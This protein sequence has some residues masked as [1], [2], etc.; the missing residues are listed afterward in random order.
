MCKESNRRVLSLEARVAVIL[1]T[2]ASSYLV[3]FREG[4]HGKDAQ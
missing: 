1:A 3:L 4:S 2:L